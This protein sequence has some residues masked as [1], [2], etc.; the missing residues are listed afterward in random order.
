MKNKCQ[1]CGEDFI[2]ISSRK[3]CSSSCSATYSNKTR[4]RKSNK[5]LHSCKNCGK[6]NKNKVFCDG[7]CNGE[8]KSKLAYREFIEGENKLYS[9]SYSPKS[10]KKYI[11]LEQSNKCLICGIKNE[12]CEK[13]IVFV[14][15]HID[16][17][18][19]N[20]TRVNLR[21][22]CPNCDSQ[23]DTFKSKNKG[24]G[25]H[26]RLKRRNEGKSY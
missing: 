16:G 5:I 6:L 11:L 7:K 15:D 9:E 21:L 10:F 8:Y 3:Y 13:P 22:V 18:A 17:N 24:K 20:N 26:F 12:W 23:L 19:E 25:R 14:M 2:G 4:I 1:N